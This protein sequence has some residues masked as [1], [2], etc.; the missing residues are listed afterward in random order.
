MANGKVKVGI[1]GSK[2]QGDI[3]AASFQI[4][5]E[6]A[7]VVAVCSPTPGHA[8]E[9]AQKYGIP[10][11]F[12]DYKEMLKEK[13]I[14]MVTVAAPNA[15]HCGMTTDIARAGKHVVCEKPL[16]MTLAE[17]DEMIDVCRK[18]G[19]LLLY[20]EELLFTPKYV[21]GKLYLVKQSEKHFGPHSDWFWD[22]NRSGGGVYMDMGCHGIAFCYWFFNRSPIKSVTCHMGTYVHG[23]RTR[24]ED[25][26]ICILEF[27]NG[28][29][30]M[31]ENSW[32]KRGGM[33]DRTEIYGEGGVS[34][35][36][37]HMGNAMPTYS[38]Y[39]YG[40]AV[41]K[42]PSTKGWTYPVFDELWN[43]GSPHEMRHFARCVHGKEKPQSTGEDGRVVMEALYAGYASAGQGRKIELPFRPEGVKRP[44]D[45]WLGTSA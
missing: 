1:I 30:G 12:L 39:G 21:N 38:E 14:E 43:Y 27:A 44:I 8:A 9:L 18:E 40:Y 16:C 34:Y 31:V 37:L 7:E 13:D 24:G 20:A 19:V 36:N 15:L 42:A 10:R 23:A 41:E 26:S 22:V 33:D 4:M 35:P 2:F 32:A 29:V 25:D 28:G 11:V 5:P 17:A 6:E 3:H 45:L